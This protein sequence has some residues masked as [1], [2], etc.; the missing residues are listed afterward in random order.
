[1]PIFNMDSKKVWVRSVTGFDEPMRGYKD[2][3]VPTRVVLLLAIDTSICMA[4][5][6]AL[7]RIQMKARTHLLIP[8]IWDALTTQQHGPK[9]KYFDTAPIYGEWVKKPHVDGSGARGSRLKT[10]MRKFV[11]KVMAK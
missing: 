6:S 5:C 3:N 11:S 9:I 4:G 8:M 7:N 1:M 2:F 10:M